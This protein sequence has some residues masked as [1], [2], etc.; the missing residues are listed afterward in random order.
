MTMA[1][2][3]NK[4][5]VIWSFMAILAISSSATAVITADVTG[6][7]NP[8][9]FAF[10]SPDI[11]YPGII[12]SDF[13]QRPEGQRGFSGFV[14]EVRSAVRPAG[15]A[16]PPG[17]ANENPLLRNRIESLPAEITYD[18]SLP[19]KIGT[20]TQTGQPTEV[21]LGLSVKQIVNDIPPSSSIIGERSRPTSGTRKR[22]GRLA[23]IG[24][25]RG[26]SISSGGSWLSG[27]FLSTGGSGGFTGFGFDLQP[28]TF[29]ADLAIGVYTGPGR[30]EEEVSKSLKAL[31][32]I[33]LDLVFNPFVYFGGLV[34][35]VL[36]FMSR[37]RSSSA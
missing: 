11:V 32:Q 8:D 29:P 22:V 10:R 28:L 27:G 21:F 12:Q 7:S 5:T 3:F 14:E 25:V 37:F 34:V 6:P 26:S 17:Q 24:S 16:P 19:V 18:E 35:A 4:L 36:M 2:I 30:S 1:V 23:S 15:G 31:R 9:I 20:D 13:S 33:V